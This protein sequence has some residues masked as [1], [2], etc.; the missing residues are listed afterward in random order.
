V[1]VYGYP[2]HYPVQDY[3]L[4]IYFGC[5]PKNVADLTKTAFDVL[6]KIKKSGV[7]EKDMVKIKE[8]LRREYEVN[9]KENRFWSGAISNNYYDNENILDIPELPKM[10]E[11]LTPD[12]LKK[13][14]NLYLNQKNYAKFV[15]MPEK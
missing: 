6:E 14:A 11:A 4:T 8:T 12:D 3:S 1:S 9:F 13:A 7:E 15:L 10:A 5:D 2:A